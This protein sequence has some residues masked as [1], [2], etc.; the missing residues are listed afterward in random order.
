MARYQ[1]K[2]ANS[3]QPNTPAW[4]CNGIHAQYIARLAPKDKSPIDSETL[5]ARWHTSLRDTRKASTNMMPPPLL[6]PHQSIL[7][8]LEHHYKAHPYRHLLQVKSNHMAIITGY[9]KNNFKAQPSQ[10][11]LICK[12]FNLRTMA[13][14]LTSWKTR[15]LSDPHC[16][17]YACTKSYAGQRIY[18]S[19]CKH[20]SYSNLSSIIRRRHTPRFQHPLHLSMHSSPR[21]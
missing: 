20:L 13:G 16:M 18:I 17:S 15:R 2:R 11:A 21:M 8:A 7:A 10:E 19:Y 14:C 6:H 12:P 4:R 1:P 3:P 5:Y 9:R